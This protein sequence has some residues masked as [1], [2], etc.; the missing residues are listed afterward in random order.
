MPRNSSVSKK[1]KIQKKKKREATRVGGTSSLWKLELDQGSVTNFRFDQRDRND[2]L[3]PVD[4]IKTDFAKKI[5]RRLDQDPLLWLLEKDIFS[6][7]LTKNLEQVTASQ[8]HKSQRQTAVGD[9]RWLLLNRMM[10]LKR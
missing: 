10:K 5:T 6:M 4:S 3:S 8:G 1:I 7:T 9:L 2:R